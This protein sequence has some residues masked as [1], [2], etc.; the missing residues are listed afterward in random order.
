MER[1]AREVERNTQLSSELQ[2]GESGKQVR[3]HIGREEEDEQN[4]SSLVTLS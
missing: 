1:L 2:E 4:S 3:R